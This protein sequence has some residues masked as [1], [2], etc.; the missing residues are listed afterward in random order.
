MFEEYK[1]RVMTAYREKHLLGELSNNISN[2]T[3]GK[4]KEECK[5]VYETRELIG[6]DRQILRDFFGAIPDMTD[7]KSI[8]K[9]FDRDR[10]RPLNSFLHDNNRIP[11][12]KNIE[13]LAWL[14]DYQDRPF[15]FDVF[16]SEGEETP[17]TPDPPTIDLPTQLV[18]RQN[19]YVKWSTMAFVAAAVT[20]GVSSVI[21]TPAS[22]QCMYWNIDHYE[23]I[24]CHQKVYGKDIVA[25]DTAKVTN[26]RLITQPDTLTAYAIGRVWYSKIDNVVECFTS[27]GKHPIHGYRQL[28]PITLPILR[29]YCSSK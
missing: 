5:F 22:E 15:R 18:R 16:K 6:S 21:P 7:F 28:K 14:I 3:P 25:I 9:N 20:I 17:Q 19:R 10:F 26:F 29:T 23:P 27:K 24:A 8:I 2:S 1:M 13:L 4:L 12:G 11:D